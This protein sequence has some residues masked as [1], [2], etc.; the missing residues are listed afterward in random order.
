MEEEI[1]SAKKIV[2]V[3]AFNEFRDEEYFLPKEILEQAGLEV[4]TASNKSGT[5]LGADG[6][7]VPVDY[8]VG[9]L[10]VNNFDAIV[11]VG[12]PGC[13]VN[14]DNEN[15]YRLA[16]EAQA[17]NKILAAICISSVILAKAGVLK[18]KQATVWSGPLD[19]SAIKI[20]EQ[21]GAAYKPESVVVD[22]NIIT[23]EGPAVAEKFAEAIINKLK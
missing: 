14:L 3:I 8:L 17:G 16:K 11:F 23:G 19:K 21:N 15:S 12:G 9:E 7:H 2:M 5:A 6:G 13:L 22:G 4:K 10:D 1:L 20:L 18:G